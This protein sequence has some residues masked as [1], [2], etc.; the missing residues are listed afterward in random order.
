MFAGNLKEWQDM[1]FTKMR[2]LNTARI[3]N[4]PLKAQIDSLRV[5]VAEEEKR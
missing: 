1:M 3:L 5:L 4:V 2:E